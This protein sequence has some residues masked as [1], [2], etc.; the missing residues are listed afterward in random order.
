MPDL[1]PPGK[2]ILGGILNFKNLEIRLFFF[3]MG[4]VE[5]GTQIN[6]DPSDFQHHKLIFNIDFFVDHPALTCESVTFRDRYAI[7]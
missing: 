2:K 3:D 1:L 4:N 6:F 7:Y 5:C